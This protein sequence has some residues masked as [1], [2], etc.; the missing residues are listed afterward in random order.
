MDAVSGEEDPCLSYMIEWAW[1]YVLGESQGAP[2]ELVLNP[3]RTPPWMKAR[4]LGDQAGTKKEWDD[5][6]NDEWKEVSRS[7]RNLEE[8]GMKQDSDIGV[9]GVSGGPKKCIKVPKHLAE[10]H[11]ARLCQE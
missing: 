7:G 10:K 8:D 5:E 1:W 4:Q 6:W 2:C 3:S 11:R 9:S